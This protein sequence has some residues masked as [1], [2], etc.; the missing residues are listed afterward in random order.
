MEKLQLLNYQR[1]SVE[2]RQV[3]MKGTLVSR[4]G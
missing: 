1:L 4:G 2:P 3:H